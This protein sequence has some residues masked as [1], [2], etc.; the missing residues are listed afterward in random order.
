MIITNSLPSINFKGKIIDSHTHCG[1]WTNDTF[2]TDDIVEFFNRKYNHKKD[3]IDKAIISNL[4][5]VIKGSDNNPYKDE[6]QGNISL[7]REC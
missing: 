1:K 2:S 4:D 3:K 5:C 7:L 6:L